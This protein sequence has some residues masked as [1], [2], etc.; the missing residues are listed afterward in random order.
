ML[1]GELFLPAS[2]KWVTGTIKRRPVLCYLYSNAVVVIAKDKKVSI[3]ALVRFGCIN[4][5][6]NGVEKDLWCSGTVRINIII[7][8]NGRVCGALVQF[9]C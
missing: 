5:D 2:S 7:D 9:G 6:M 4:T 8:V 3:L 1:L